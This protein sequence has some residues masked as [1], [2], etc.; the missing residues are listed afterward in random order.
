MMYL[1]FTIWPISGTENLI[2][3]VQYNADIFDTY[4]DI[5]L[6]NATQ[7]R[8]KGKKKVSV[9]YPASE[10]DI[11]RLSM[12]EIICDERT[13]INLTMYF[14]HQLQKHCCLRNQCFVICY[15]QEWKDSVIVAGEKALINI[16]EET[17]MCIPYCLHKINGR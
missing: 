15:H 10:K 14:I 5:S 17:D 4:Q 11:N 12:K 3:S 2:T 1:H 13:K 6:K 9:E 16:H 7:T 8:Q